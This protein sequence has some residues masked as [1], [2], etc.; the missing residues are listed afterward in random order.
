MVQKFRENV[1]ISNKVNFR[2]YSKDF[3]KIRQTCSST[4]PT[5]SARSRSN[6]VKKRNASCG[7]TVLYK[8]F[9]VYKARKLLSFLQVYTFYGPLSFVFVSTSSVT[10]LLA[11]SIP[12]RRRNPFIQ[13]IVEIRSVDTDVFFKRHSFSFGTFSLRKLL[14][15][16]YIDTPITSYIIFVIKI[17]VMHAESRNSRKYCSP[18]IWSYTVF[19]TALGSSVSIVVV[20]MVMVHMEEKALTCSS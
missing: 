10:C 1:E 7:N 12:M 13:R 11:V 8:E 18:K 6:I 5:Y 16:R 2:D 20:V 3:V 17:F 15:T 4:P 9:Y 19:G 14:N